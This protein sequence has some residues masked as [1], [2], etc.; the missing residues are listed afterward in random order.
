[1]SSEQP[2]TGDPAEEAPASPEFPAA[3]LN[4]ALPALRRPFSPNAVQWKIQASG[5]KGDEP[6]YAIVIGYIDARLVIERLNMVVGGAWSEKPVRI[7][8]TTGALMYELTVFDTTHVDVGVAQGSTEEMKLKATHSDA[9]KRSAVRFGVGVSLY[10]MPQFRL[11]VTASEEKRDG[12]P[13]LP[14]RNGKPGGLRDAHLK[15]LREQYQ[16]WL[17]SESGK[18]FGEPLD[19]GD[20]L[21]AV[22]ALAEA[23]E[24]GEESAVPAAPP[25][26]VEKIAALATEARNL[27]D[28]VRTFDDDALADTT[29][30]NALSQREHSAERMEDF[31]ASLRE[32]RANVERFT[33]LAA[34]VEQRLSP[35]EAKKLLGRAQRRGS[36]AER[37]QVLEEGLAAIADQEKSE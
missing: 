11:T 22:G 23:P 34:D 29:F 28:E 1:M 35:A 18:S 10:A 30:D 8:D 20:A 5:P 27:R 25:E 17:G 2:A 14:R 19:H 3:D 37:V 36:R 33:I 26:E 32:L 15:W 7:A 6:T 16:A 12:I 4:A 13:T 9:L 31:V 21:E 24:G